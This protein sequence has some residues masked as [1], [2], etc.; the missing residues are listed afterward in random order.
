MTSTPHKIGQETPANT[1]L[2]Q[3]EILF[4]EEMT[5]SLISDDDQEMIV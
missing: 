1:N 2:Y 3:A 5:E 4:D